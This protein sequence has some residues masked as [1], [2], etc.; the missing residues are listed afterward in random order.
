MIY[1]FK[2]FSLLESSLYDIKYNDSFKK[3]IFDSWDIPDYEKFIDNF[4]YET[5]YDGL[6]LDD[7]DYDEIEEMEEYKNW[8]EI[9]NEYIFD[10]IK[11]KIDSKIEDG[12]LTIWR[13]ITVDEKWLDHFIKHGK[14]L[15]IYWSWEES[16]AE[17]HW[18]YGEDKNIEVRFQCTIDE[19]QVNWKDTILLN[20][21]PGLGEEEKEI[22][23]VKNT[24][25]KLDSITI[26]NEEYD[27]S[28][29]KNRVFLS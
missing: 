22:R 25:L 6:E 23:L 28:K 7:K 11:S 3:N 18:G 20:M 14:H 27:I 17:A 26:E 9:E 12:Q 10:N 13:V 1:N 24:R 2:K 21:H 29:F 8:L 5:R 15:G 19:R 4:K 16:S